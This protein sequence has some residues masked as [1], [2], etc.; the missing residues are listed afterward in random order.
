MSRPHES[1]TRVVTIPN[2]IT[3]VRLLALPVIVWLILTHANGWAL[4]L[5]IAAGVSD[6]VDGFIARATGQTSR[7]GEL[8]DPISD[9]LYIACTLIAMGIASVVPWWVVV[10][11]LARDLIVGSFLA[12]LRRRGVTGI[13]VTFLGK[14]ATFLLMWGFPLLLVGATD[15][16]V[17]PTCSVPP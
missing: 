17:A 6:Y 11:L 2:A 1:T 3:A 8:L 9:R 13:P 12:V 14:T 4:A 10:A 5:L 16:S 7:I 15:W